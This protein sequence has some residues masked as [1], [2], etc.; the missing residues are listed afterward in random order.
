MKYAGKR[1]LMLLLTMVIVSL[2]TF[3]AFELIHGNAVEILGHPT[4][5]A[6]RCGS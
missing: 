6:S 3:V 5:T 2:L 1:V 4:A